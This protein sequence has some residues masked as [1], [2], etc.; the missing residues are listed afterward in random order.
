MTR[1]LAPLPILLLCFGCETAGTA[2]RI[3]V[4]LSGGA[5]NVRMDL[6]P[7]T[8]T[9]DVDNNVEIDVAFDPDENATGEAASA[10][11]TQY[12]IDYGFG[13]CAADGDCAP[14]ISGELYLEVFEGTT[15][16]LTVRGAVEEQLDWVQARYPGDEFDVPARIS[17]AGAFD[18]LE[19]ITVSSDYTAIFADFR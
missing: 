18:E 1:A 15:E 17:L 4:T 9:S 11:F 14:Y 7:I 12:R 10:I 8:L 2:D 13:D 16:S 6:E 3:A 19:G 5:P